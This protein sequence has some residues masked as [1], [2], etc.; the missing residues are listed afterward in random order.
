[1]EKW[2]L[3]KKSAEN[4]LQHTR[5]EGTRHAVMPLALQYPTSHDRNRFNRLDGHWCADVFFN[6]IE[7]IGRYK[8]ALLVYSGE[9]CWTMS[10]H[11]KSDVDKAIV[12][13]CYQVGIMRWLTTDA[14][15]EFIGRKCGFRAFLMSHD[16]GIKLE[17]TARGQQRH[18]KAENG[19][20]AIKQ[21]VHHTMETEGVHSRLWPYCLAYETDIFKR[22]W[23]P[24]NNRTASVPR[25]D[26]KQK[27]RISFIVQHQPLHFH[28]NATIIPSIHRDFSAYTIIGRAMC[29]GAGQP[30]LA[31]RRGLFTT[32][33]ISRDNNC[34]LPSFG[35]KILI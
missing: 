19:V 29:Y 11:S 27:E 5:Q 15:N 25:V 21:R 16:T 14:A 24:K 23:R 33:T 4:T 3:S 32:A 34:K 20:K 12:E 28:Q 7:G 6:S 2:H 30:F 17:H 9:F 18:N 1:M 8:C 22:I 35:L 31:G 10:L 26:K 13:F